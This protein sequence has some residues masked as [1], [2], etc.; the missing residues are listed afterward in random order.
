MGALL[1]RASQAVSITRLS[2]STKELFEKLKSG[3]ENRFVVLK[4]NTPAGVVLSVKAF[5][6]L[7]EEIEDLRIEAVARER[8]KTWDR[9]KTIS[10]EEMMRRFGPR[11]R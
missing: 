9:S 5:E 3:K 6:A 2:R 8:L 1:D 7:L 4:N 10:H 11:K